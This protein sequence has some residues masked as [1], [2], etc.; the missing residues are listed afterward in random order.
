MSPRPRGRPHR[1]SPDRSRSQWRDARH[2]DS[3]RERRRYRDRDRDRAGN[4]GRD[5]DRD[6]DRLRHRD[7]SRDRH[8]DRYGHRHSVDRHHW[9]HERYTDRSRRSYEPSRCDACRLLPCFHV[10]MLLVIIP[11]RLPV[12]LPTCSATPRSDSPETDAA[13]RGCSPVRQRVCL[14]CICF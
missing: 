10:T 3:S 14:A 13:W 5:R 4:R 12:F 11:T 6:S 2:Q 8:G 7:A 1:R 9:E